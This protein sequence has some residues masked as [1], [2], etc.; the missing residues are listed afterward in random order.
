MLKTTFY[1]ECRG[2]NVRKK[3]FPFSLFSFNYLG[4]CVLKKLGNSTYMFATTPKP[5]IFAC[6]LRYEI[7]TVD[8]RAIDIF[9]A[10]LFL[11]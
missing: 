9:I 6:R 2:R 3:K 11:Y 4:D 1:T 10:H 5:L 8:C 7:M